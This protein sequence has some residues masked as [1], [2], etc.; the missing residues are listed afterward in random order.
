MRK[1]FFKK[2]QWEEEEDQGKWKGVPPKFE[3]KADERY[4][5]ILQL[6][7]QVNMRKS[8]LSCAEAKHIIL[9]E[10]KDAGAISEVPD[11]EGNGGILRTDSGMREASEAISA[12]KRVPAKDT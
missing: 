7:I 4:G 1:N 8:K 11:T 12:M 6:F 9:C 2:Y 5:F 3:L 10:L